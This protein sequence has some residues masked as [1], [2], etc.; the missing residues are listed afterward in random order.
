MEFFTKYTRLETVKLLCQ[1]VYLRTGIE[2]KSIE[3]I[4]QNV[5]FKNKDDVPEKGHKIYSKVLFVKAPF[6]DFKK[7]Q[8]I[9]PIVDEAHLSDNHDGVEKDNGIDSQIRQYMS[10]LGRVNISRRR[11]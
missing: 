3:E 6:L 1:M 2:T 11:Y 9:N 10:N 5:E 8:T 4:H 7:K